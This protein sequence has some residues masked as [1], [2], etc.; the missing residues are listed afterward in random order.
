MLFRSVAV[1]VREEVPAEKTEE[2]SEE[3]SEEKDMTGSE[4]SE[5]PDN[6]DNL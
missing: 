6:N 5:K 4:N 1:N 3:K 2:Q